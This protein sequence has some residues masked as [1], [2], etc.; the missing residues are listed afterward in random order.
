[1]KEIKLTQGKVVL[2]DDEDYEYLNQF[3]WYALKNHRTYYAQRVIQNNYI[4]RTLKMHRVI[5]DTPC[6]LEVDHID[7]DG[8][9]NQKCNL[10]NCTF[11]EN[12]KNRKPNLKK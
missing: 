5:M 4:K 11:A 10:R 8:L 2:V 6:G 1:M 3:K 12:R 9:N 7:G